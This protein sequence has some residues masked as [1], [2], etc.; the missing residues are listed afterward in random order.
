MTPLPVLPA[1]WKTTSMPGLLLDEL[2]AVGAA[3]GLVDEALVK[4]LADTHALTS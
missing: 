2:G 3:A 4:S 1:T